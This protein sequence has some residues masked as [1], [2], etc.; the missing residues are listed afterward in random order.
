MGEADVE[1][2]SYVGAVRLPGFLDLVE[3]LKTW[4]TADGRIR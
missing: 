2:A 1:L 4:E 3:A